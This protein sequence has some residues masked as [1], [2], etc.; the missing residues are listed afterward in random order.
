MKR[1]PI[2]GFKVNFDIRDY[3]DILPQPPEILADIINYDKPSSECI[4]VKKVPEVITEKYVAQEYERCLKTGVWI[5]LNKQLIW[6]P[7]NFYFFLQYGTAGG[8][9][10]KLRLKRLKQVYFKIRVRKNPRA[11]GTYTI[12]NRQDGETTMAIHDALWECLDGN[13]AVGQ[14]GIQSKTN[15]DAKNPCW[16]TLQALWQVIPEWFKDLFFSDFASKGAMAEKVKFERPKGEGKEARQILISYYPSVHNAMDGKNNMRICILD[17]INKWRECSFYDTYINYKKFIAVGSSRRGLLN[18]FSSPSDTNGR[19]N[20]EA[21]TFWKGSNPDELTVTGSTATRVFRYYSDPLEGIEGFYDEFGDADADEI[22]E[23][24]LQE[25]ANMPEDKRMAEVRAF[26]LNEMEMFGSYD[27]NTNNWANAKGINERIV[28]L[29]NRRFKDDITKE[30][31]ALYGNLEWKDGIPDNPE[32][33]VFRQHDSNCFDI[34][35]ARFAFSFLP[36]HMDSLKWVWKHELQGYR[37]KVPHVTQYATGIDPVDKRYSM[38]NKRGHSNGS[39]VTV[40][41]LDLDMDGIKDVPTVFYKCRPQHINTFF[42]D[43]IKICIFMQSPCNVENKNTKIVDW[44]EDR[45]YFDWLLAKKGEHKNS[46]IKG[47]APGTGGA[48]LN[49]MM[50]LID[51]V[52]NVPLTEDDK[53]LLEDIWFEELLEDTL[54]LDPKNTQK[55]DGF[56]AWGQAMIGKTK[57][58]QLKSVRPQSTITKGAMDFLLN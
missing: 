34:E 8:E 47:D 48:F 58:M 32:G 46:N 4:W 16:L 28:F 24:I 19:W 36:K 22:K 50:M 27:E 23:F 29:K 43:A 56:N 30:P 15:D 57:L 6:L 12:K 10:P 54:L 49:E 2:T 5:F 20:D 52:T 45:G 33:V 25:R 26:P 53:Y 55:S 17:E 14:I 37:P 9:A 44:F 21:Y 1:N 3:G 51:S 35:K 40:K 42:E 31:V 38:G 11:I 7:P 13:M 39:I 18:I 41:Y